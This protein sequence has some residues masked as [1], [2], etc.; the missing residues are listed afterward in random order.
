MSRFFVN[1]EDLPYK[2]VGL[3]VSLKKSF[4]EQR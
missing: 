3:L 2:T 1:I 4:F